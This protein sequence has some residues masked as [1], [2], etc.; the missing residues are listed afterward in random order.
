MAKFWLL[1]SL[2]M[3]LAHAQSLEE[4]KLAPCKN[5]SWQ[6]R[7]W[8][9]YRV[10]DVEPCLKSY[11]VRIHDMVV[12][13]ENLFYGVSSIY[14][15]T[16]IAL[17]SAAS[18]QQNFCDLE[19]HEVKVDL[20]HELRELWQH[21]VLP[22]AKV[23]SSS[24]SPTEI[25]EKLLAPSTVSTLDF[26][27]KLNSIFSG[28][29]DAHTVYLFRS[30]VYQF[31][32]VMFSLEPTEGGPRPFRIMAQA[33]LE[34]MELLRLAKKTSVLNSTGLREVA[35][36]NGQDPLVWLQ[37]I[38]DRRGTYHDASQR[39]NALILEMT[40][41]ESMDLDASIGGSVGG[42]MDLVTPDQAVVSIT[43]AG[44]NGTLQEEQVEW[45]VMVD[46]R[47]LER[48]LLGLGD[49][50]LYFHDLEWRRMAWGDARAA[51]CE[52]I[53]NCSSVVAKTHFGAA[54]GYRRLLRDAG[55]DPSEDLVTEVARSVT[56]ALHDQPRQSSKEAEDE[57]QSPFK[58]HRAE[59]SSPEKD[60]D[61][62]AAVA[63]TQAC[64]A[65]VTLPH[66]HT[67]QAIF[68][69]KELTVLTMGDMMVFKLASFMAST[70]EVFAG[71]KEMVT[72]ARD[73][74]I[75]RV[76]IDV[77][78]N[79]GGLVT[80][81][82][83]LRSL[84][85]KDYDPQS[86][87]MDYNVRINSLWEAWI[88]SF[89]HGL[90]QD[91]AD[92]MEALSAELANAPLE[93]AKWAVRWQLRYLL[94]VVDV[95]NKLLGSRGDCYKSNGSPSDDCLGTLM[96]DANT[97]RLAIDE[98][99]ATHSVP[100]LLEALK[101]TLLRKDFIPAVIYSSDEDPNDP[102]ARG[103]S[104]FFPDEILVRDTMDPFPGLAELDPEVQQWGG[105][106]ASFSKRG[107]W[108]ICAMAGVATGSALQRAA[109][110]GAAD[111]SGYRD[112]PFKEIA[113]LTDGL[114]GSASSTF[115][116]GL[117]AS[118]FVT[119]FTYGGNGEP[120]DT[121]GFAGG[122]VED[123]QG[124]WPTVAMAAEFGMWLQPNS[125]WERLSRAKVPTHETIPLVETVIYP[126]PMPTR[127]TVSTFN[128]HIMYVPLFEAG[129]NTTLPRQFY[130][131]PAHKHYSVW[132]R[133]LDD[134][135]ANP[136]GLLEMYRK[137]LNEDWILVRLNP[138][139]LNKGWGQQCVPEPDRAECCSWDRRLQHQ[140]DAPGPVPSAPS[141]SL[142]ALPALAGLLSFAGWAWRRRTEGTAQ[143][144]LAAEALESV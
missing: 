88:S 33:S 124:W 65:S 7:K 134:V 61:P 77:V 131:V 25:G 18:V 31:L 59:G 68:T 67:A 51:E 116:T 94:G 69:G 62:A 71:F 42:N 45:V 144:R 38:A 143:I 100:E 43:F 53:P 32:P 76:L 23:L 85:V 136:Q 121:T 142:A 12:T 39:L 10:A 117:I 102:T 27:L 41:T 5:K 138:Q 111:L 11:K 122:N 82:D 1:F 115:V 54:S 34:V 87:C 28:L 13:M 75:T 55:M 58:R 19:V 64:L 84:F 60:A 141:M 20:Q 73:T 112:H 104:P 137:I 114:A 118:G 132:P 133:R 8:Q 49:D 126:Y 21:S 109:R 81:S 107:V 89:G 50:Y 86:L 2:T 30:G 91:I 6:F 125:T 140:E 74:G 52:R 16:P 139:Y 99:D 72:Y 83:L 128:F 63:A 3:S 9:V 4:D 14:S 40:L 123:Y 56:R 46:Q 113:V 48:N 106:N 90:E 15:F 57:E 92:R 22:A 98:L 24:S 80:L 110:S 101:T 29:N 70:K 119:A 97:L 93:V 78:T 127:G 95:S 130:R 17:D 120:M 96:V 79:G 135:C 66:L 129:S 108:N 44:F 36:I 103:W 37:K 47:K 105:V 26:H 35:L